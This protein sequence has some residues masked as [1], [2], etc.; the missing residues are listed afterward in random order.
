[1]NHKVVV[2]SRTRI[3]AI[4]P[5][6]NQHTPLYT[7]PHS[8]HGDQSTTQPENES[9]AEKADRLLAAMLLFYKETST[10]PLIN[11]NRS[12]KGNDSSPT[13][14]LFHEL[15]SFTQQHSLAQKFISRGDSA[16]E[17]QSAMVALSTASWAIESSNITIIDYLFWTIANAQAVFNVV[18]A[19]IIEGALVRGCEKLLF[20]CFHLKDIDSCYPLRTL[21]ASICIE[22]TCEGSLPL[23][24]RTSILK[25]ILGPAEFI[26]HHLETRIQL[27]DKIKT[28]LR[29]SSFDNI[30]FR[31]LVQRIAKKIGLQSPVSTLEQLKFRMYQY[32]DHVVFDPEHF[33]RPKRITEYMPAMHWVT[34]LEHDHIVS[35]YLTQFRPQMLLFLETIRTMDITPTL[36]DADRPI[37][38]ILP[39][40]PGGLEEMDSLDVHAIASAHSM[41]RSIIRTAGI[42]SE[43]LKLL[44]TCALEYAMD[45][46]CDWVGDLR[47]GPLQHELTEESAQLL[48]MLKMPKCGRIDVTKAE[49][50]LGWMT[51]VLHSIPVAP[52]HFLPS[53]LRATLMC[54]AGCMHIEETLGSTLIDQN[55]T[56]SAMIMAGAAFR[57]M[58]LGLP[59]QILF[60][61]RAQIA[62]ALVDISDLLRDS[63]LVSS[64]TLWRGMFDPE[65]C[66][67][68]FP[69][70]ETRLNSLG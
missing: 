51:Q 47:Y 12:N 52:G 42:F 56:S 31:S 55:K 63:S 1:M 33:T 50:L 53:L 38:T 23:Y 10:V 37:I 29:K 3:T 36:T 7:S 57:L 46:I 22:M 60:Q 11:Q 15:H 19:S 17:Q 18:I 69:I 2:E 27:S 21:A 67:H 39:S 49:Q 6:H 45:R 24:A 59:S 54:F 28:L 61:D 26:L 35:C 48:E 14:P 5:T 25:F 65:T 41:A 62:K 9:D 30:E 34:L 64:S 16:K 58:S 68:P 66:P 70:L 20:L 4:N 32:L 40:C 13:P 43:D 8:N 44:N